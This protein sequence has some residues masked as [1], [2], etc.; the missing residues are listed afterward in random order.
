M[1][2]LKEY[3]SREAV[4]AFVSISR[5]SGHEIPPASLRLIEQAS[6]QPEALLEFVRKRESRG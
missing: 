5:I 3:N 6:R 2:D 1:L 4:Q